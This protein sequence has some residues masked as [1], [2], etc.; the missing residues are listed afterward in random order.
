MEPGGS[1][2]RGRKT[3]V[4]VSEAC[5]PIER[6]YKKLLEKGPGRV[7]PLLVPMMIS[8]M[9]VRKRGHPVWYEGQMHQRGNRLCNRY[10]LHR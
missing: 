7:N 4:P 6:E 9:A 1:V 5:R 2:P 8:N 3:L 10:P